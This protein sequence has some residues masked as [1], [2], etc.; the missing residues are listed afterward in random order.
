MKSFTVLLS[1]FFVFSV[2]GLDENKDLT[3]LHNH[4]NDTGADIAK[5]VEELNNLKEKVETLEYRVEIIENDKPNQTEVVCSSQ[6]PTVE[7]PVTPSTPTIDP[8][9]VGFVYVQLPEEKSPETLWPSL[10]WADISNSYSGVFFRVLGGESEPIGVVQSSFAPSIDSIEYDDC[11]ENAPSDPNSCY[12]KGPKNTADLG[13]AV[14]GWTDKVTTAHFY[15][16]DYSGKQVSWTSSV[17]FHSTQG[18]VR[19]QNMAVKV[20]QRID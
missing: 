17:R 18:E 11:L 14:D 8:V 7:T 12:R 1:C 16:S 2:K 4:R 3:A 10:K 20:W 15:S 6:C 19:P 5:L 13:S 9:P